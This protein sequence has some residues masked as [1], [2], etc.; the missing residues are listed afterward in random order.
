MTHDALYWCSVLSLMHQFGAENLNGVGW[1]AEVCKFVSRIPVKMSLKFPIICEKL[2]PRLAVE[3][4]VT[5]TVPACK[6]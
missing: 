4:A 3:V 5:G 2:G 1:G 6:P